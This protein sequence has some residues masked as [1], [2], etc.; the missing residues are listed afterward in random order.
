MEDH[1][2]QT[3]SLETCVCAFCSGSVPSYG[4]FRFIREDL[5]AIG[6][7][8]LRCTLSTEPPA[9][10]AH[11]AFL[12][13]DELEEFQVLSLQGRYPLSLDLAALPQSKG[14]FGL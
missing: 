3:G 4:G 2:R 14:E 12:R 11:S 1:R 10:L 7:R 9:A 8:D 5:E 6:Q 13:P